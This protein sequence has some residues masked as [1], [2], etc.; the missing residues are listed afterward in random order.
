MIQDNYEIANI[1]HIENIVT[2]SFLVALQR[3][4]LF[5]RHRVTGGGRS[6]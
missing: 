1:L 2:Y 6:I 4:I 5:I 3:Y